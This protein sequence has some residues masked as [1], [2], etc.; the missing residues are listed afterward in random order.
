MGYLRSLLR[1]PR[2]D[3]DVG[4]NWGFWAVTII[5]A[6]LVG[7]V[8][9]SF[10]GLFT[11]WRQR[12]H[13]K[14]VQRAEHAHLEADHEAERRHQAALQAQQL[15]HEREMLLLQRQ[16]ATLARR[17]ERHQEVAEGVARQLAGCIEWFEYELGTTYG[18]EADYYPELSLVPEAVTSPKQV[19]AV[20]QGISHV[21]PTKAVRDAAD[22][23]RDKITGHYGAIA[24]NAEGHFVT[25]H[26]PSMD[27]LIE[28]HDDLARLLERVHEPPAD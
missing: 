2:Q 12:G 17:D 22:A 10:T 3:G 16:Q 1:G 20:L 4:L 26:D 6:G 23:L 9:E 13:E 25:M 15:E 11:G 28:W 19:A 24:P 27:Q 21:H 14:E 5:G 18:P 7:V 8:V